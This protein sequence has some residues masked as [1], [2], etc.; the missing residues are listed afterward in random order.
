MSDVDED[1]HDVPD[2]VLNHAVPTLLVYVIEVSAGMGK[3]GTGFVR[4]VITLVQ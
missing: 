4:T 2:F 1:D 3:Y